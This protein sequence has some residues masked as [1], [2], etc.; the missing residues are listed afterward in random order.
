MVEF[1]QVA[2]L[3]PQG[4]HLPADN[5]YPGIHAVT[6]EARSQANPLV[7]HAEQVPSTFK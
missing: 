2:K 7:A 1:T 5:T 6:V 4:S 3:D